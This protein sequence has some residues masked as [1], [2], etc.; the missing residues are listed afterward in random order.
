MGAQWPAPRH[1][2]SA[3]CRLASPCGRLVWR[4]SSSRPATA[5]FT[6]PSFGL[7]RGLKN[8][9]FRGR[10]T[11]SLHWLPPE[12][13][14]RQEESTLPIGVSRAIRMES[15]TA[16]ASSAVSKDSWA[17]CLKRVRCR[18]VEP[19][20]PLPKQ[21]GNA[22]QLLVRWLWGTLVPPDERMGRAESRKG[23]TLVH[24]RSP[25]A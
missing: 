18:R 2:A 7:A 23:P 1:T 6:F 24:G 9:R 22:D 12:R 20:G 14:T 11:D 10:P 5:F 4:S 13:P 16:R 21:S 8:N 17:P 15:R 25:V 19:P 3:R